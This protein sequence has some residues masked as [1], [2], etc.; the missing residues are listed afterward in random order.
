[1]GYMI[2]DVYISAQEALVLSCK[3]QTHL[4]ILYE[5]LLTRQQLLT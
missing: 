4:R 3:S 1:M 5:I 2:Q